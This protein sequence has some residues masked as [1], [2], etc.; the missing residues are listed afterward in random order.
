M[1]LLQINSCISNE[2]L[3]PKP[4]AQDATKRK[5]E[6]TDPGSQAK[7]IADPADDQRHD[8]SA[9]NSCAQNSR[10][11]TVMVRN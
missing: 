2:R 6:E 1:S 3:R 9:H 5:V 8:R 11:G 7:M 10:E 4:Y